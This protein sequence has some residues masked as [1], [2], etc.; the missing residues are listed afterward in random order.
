MEAV[1]VLCSEL[2]QDYKDVLLDHLPTILLHILPSFAI[3]ETQDVVEDRRLRKQI[4]Q[5]TACFDTLVQH[6]P[7]KV[8]I[9]STSTTDVLVILFVIITVHIVFCKHLSRKT[10]SVTSGQGLALSTSRT[11][12]AHSR[13]AAAPHGGCYDRT[14]TDLW[15]S[16]V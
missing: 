4:A 5:M 9:S 1:Q 15:N 14:G 6:V 11:R 13:G 7:K 3:N 8:N 2:D 16:T 10:G 12:R